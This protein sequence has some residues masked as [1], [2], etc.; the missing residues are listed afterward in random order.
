MRDPGYDYLL[1]SRHLYTPKTP[2]AALKAVETG[3][4]PSEAFVYRANAIHPLREEPIDMNA[5]ERTLAQKGNDV[6]TNML[7]V[8]ILENLLH[9]RDS[10]IALFAAESINALENSYN[11]KIE[12]LKNSYKKTTNPENLKRIAEQFYELALI[13]ESRRAIRNFYLLESYSYIKQYGQA[14]EYNKDDI[15]FVIRIMIILK[16]YRLARALLVKALEEN[17]NDTE[18]IIIAAEIEYH[19][20]NYRQVFAL[21]HRLGDAW[22][23]LPENVR[24]TYQHWMPDHSDE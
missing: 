10:E 4:L 21:F 22:N 24:S 12:N 14:V 19:R 13:N 6:T 2:M 20:K 17:P 8:S 3:L 9:D 5:I 15:M 1:N 7:L 11:E 18:L 23:S 16:S